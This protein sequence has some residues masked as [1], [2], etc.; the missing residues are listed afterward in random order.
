MKERDFIEDL[1]ALTRQYWGK[2]FE[3][4]ATSKGVLIRYP[5]EIFEMDLQTMLKSIMRQP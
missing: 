3:I 4:L 2:D 5:R 1:E